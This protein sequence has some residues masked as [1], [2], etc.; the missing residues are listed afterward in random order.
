VC[1]F[2]ILRVFFPYD[3]NL[4]AFFKQMGIENNLV[5]KGSGFSFAQD[6]LEKT[7]Q[8]KVEFNPEPGFM[9]L[10]KASRPVALTA[11]AV[12]GPKMHK[13]I[14]TDRLRVYLQSLPIQASRRILLGWV[15][16][17]IRV[18]RS[19]RLFVG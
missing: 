4:M 8:L 12:A 5:W 15:T 7:V 19:G 6:K 17:K 18:D 14:I 2:P 3:V 11:L 16:R 1:R 9:P 13:R 10:M